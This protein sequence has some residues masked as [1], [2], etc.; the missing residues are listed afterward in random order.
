MAEGFLRKWGGDRFNVYSAGTEPAE[1][2]HPM[3]VE[4]MGE[5]DIDISHQEPKNVGDYLGRLSVRH[6]IIVCAGANE[7]CP[8]VFPGM[9]NRVFWPFDDPAVFVGDSAATMEE[10]RRVRDQIETRIK[11]WLEE[12]PCQ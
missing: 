4:V 9:L 3:A 1:R 2:V 10:F 11:Q 5:K 8:R 12:T 7:R 6:L